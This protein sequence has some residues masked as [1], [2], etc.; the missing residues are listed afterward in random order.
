MSTPDEETPAIV[1]KE[2]RQSKINFTINKRDLK[3]ENGVPLQLQET[4]GYVGS[5]EAQRIAEMGP[6]LIKG[7]VRIN[8]SNESWISKEPVLMIVAHGFRA[9]GEHKIRSRNGSL[10]SAEAM[11]SI[12]ADRE[13]RKETER[14]RLFISCDAETE[15]PRWD[16]GQLARQ[17]GIIGFAGKANF[18][19]SRAENEIYIINTSGLRSPFDDPNHPNRWLVDQTNSPFRRVTPI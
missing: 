11:S 14:I 16:E 13:Q 9:E 12:V 19:T 2:T 17:L 6:V 7:L 8:G 1:L 5:N 4:K 18:M 3:T 15:V 10:N